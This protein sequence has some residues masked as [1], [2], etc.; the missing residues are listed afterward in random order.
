LYTSLRLTTRR[1]STRTLPLPAPMRDP[2]TLRTLIL[3]DLESHPP[4]APIDIVRVCIEPTPAR[5]LQWTL[6]ERAQPAPEQ[7]T[8][9]M[10]RLTALMGEGHVGSPALVDSWKPGAF[11]MRE[12]RAGERGVGNG[13]Q[14]A[15]NGEPGTANREPGTGN[16]EPGTRNRE[17]GTRN[18]EPGTGNQEP[19]TLHSALRRFRFPIPTRVVVQEGRP[20]RVQ[21]DRQG[22]SS[23]AIVQA[24]GPWRTSGDWWEVGRIG[25]VGQ[26]GQ[27]GRDGGWDRDEWDVAMK[28]GTIY[29]LVVEREV[30][31]WFLEGV[32]D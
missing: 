5:V 1:V 23:G 4:D 24:A 25:R 28:D 17:Q 21:T 18:R 11:Q 30:G 27:V 16:R 31:Q 19:G 10:A 22:F 26:V 29:R 6:L 3:L 9:L 20:V 8:T 7:V 12:F 13:E 15:G 2:K 14:G 32:I